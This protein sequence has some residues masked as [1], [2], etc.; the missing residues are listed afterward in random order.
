M[1]QNKIFKF[2][3]KGSTFHADR[4]SDVQASHPEVRDAQT[5]RSKSRWSRRSHARRRRKGEKDVDAFFA[6]FTLKT[7]D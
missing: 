2:H 4:V 1:L 7:E 5:R 3:F 6:S